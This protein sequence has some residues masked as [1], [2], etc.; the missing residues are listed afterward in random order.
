VGEG[1]SVAR[2]EVLAARE[3]LDEE[4]V[5]LEASV[6]AAIDIPAKIKRSPV[7]AA[8]LVGGAAFVVLGG[9]RRVLRGARHAVFGRPEP[10]PESMLPKEIDASLR[11]LG[12][13][14]ERVRGLLE[15]EFA[16]YLQATEPARKRRDLSGALT[17]VTIAFV[18]PLVLRYSRRLA[19]QIFATDGKAYTER[20]D[21]VRARITGDTA[22]G[23]DLG[24]KP[25][26]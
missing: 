26:P 19:E 1:T 9:P 8:G 22:P 17:V 5:R 6:R 4:L 3:A 15:H 12:E 11:K 2:A 10:L 24:Q 14:G 23:V 16:S 20:L 7:K 13:D 25:E 18:R 21:A